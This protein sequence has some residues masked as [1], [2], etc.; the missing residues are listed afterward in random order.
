MMTDGAHRADQVFFE[1]PRGHGLFIKGSS[2]FATRARPG[3]PLTMRGRMGGQTSEPTTWQHPVCLTGIVNYGIEQWY[4]V[5][6]APG[7]LDRTACKDILK[8]ILVEGR[9]ASDGT[10]VI[11]GFTV[12]GKP[13]AKTVRLR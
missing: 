7:L 10:A 2:G 3:T 8:D 13:F 9:V 1:V 5:Q 12:A 4:G 6:G 11:D